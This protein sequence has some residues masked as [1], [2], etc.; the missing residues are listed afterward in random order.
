MPTELDFATGDRRENGV[1]RLPASSQTGY[2]RPF[3]AADNRGASGS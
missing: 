3:V 1:P 2:Q